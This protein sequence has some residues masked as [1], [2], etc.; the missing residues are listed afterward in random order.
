MCGV[1]SL[2]VEMSVLNASHLSQDVYYFFGV[3]F[4]VSHGASL[5]N[6]E[7]HALISRAHSLKQDGMTNEVVRNSRVSLLRT[8]FGSSLL[9]LCQ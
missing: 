2:A 5:D 1:V 7:A 3:A 4:S 9:F 6:L 8:C